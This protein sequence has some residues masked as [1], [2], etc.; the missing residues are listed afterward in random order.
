MSNGATS[1]G[2]RLV[3]PTAATLGLALVAGTVTFMASTADAA[4]LPES[5]L[6]S[7]ATWHYS[8]DNTD[9]AAGSPDR[10]VWT[11]TDYD[12]SAWKT[13]AGPFGAKRG[14][15]TGI[16]SGFPIDTL[17][18]QYIDGTSTDVPTFHFRSTF[19]VPADQLADLGALKGTIT[20]DDAVQVFVNGTQVAGFFDDR[21]EAAPE[22]QRNLTYAGVSNGDP[23]TSTFSVPVDAL[24]PGENTL[25]VALHQDRADSSD[26]Y[27]DVKSLVPVAADAPADVSDVVLHVGA[28]ETHRNLTWYTDQDVPQVVQVA[29]TADLDG[30]EFPANA[31][32]ITASGGPTTSGEFS[33]DATISGLQENTEYS[34]RVGK[35]GSW[36]ETYAFRTQDFSGAFEFLF[37]GDPQIGASGNV[38]RDGAGWADTLDVAQATY[39]D[40][41]MLFSAG[42]QVDHAANEAEYDAV[43]APEQMK[44]VPFVAT[45]GNHDV[46]SK[47]YEQHFNVPNNDPTSGAGTSTSSGGNYWFVY[48]D[49][50][51]VNIN[52][53]NRDH[54]SHEAFLEKVVAEH[55][56]EARW[57]VLAFH[58]SIYSTAAHTNDGDILDRRNAL[59]ATI[60][61]L[62]FDAVLMGHDHSYT[63]SYLLK[64][65][66]VADAGEAAG[67]AEVVA[68]EGE[69]LY[70][71]AN[72]ASGSKYYGVRA[73]DAPFA[74]VINQENVRNYSAVEVTDDTLTITTLRSQAKDGD[75]P[76]NSVV[77]EVTLKRAAT[78]QE[79][80]GDDEQRLQVKVPE[81]GTVPGELVWSI[82]GSNDL[83][84]LGTAESAGDHW[85]AAGEINPVRVTDTRTAGPVWSIS[86]Q[87]SDFASGGSSFDGKYL[88][89]TPRLAE[90]GG[91]AVAGTK[92]T[93]GL[94]GGDGLSVS[95]TLGRADAGHA[96]GSALLGADLDLRIPV[97]VTDG[98]Y[99]AT[100]TLTALS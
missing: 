67:Q 56:D 73:P 6:D 16:G 81:E 9:P 99:Q 45:N 49:V 52:S 69:V 61:D 63:R 1:L 86:A 85:A 8:D 20:F 18:T 3:R 10:L 42:D 26:I 92:V 75:R 98:T 64:D 35:E 74:S 100:L 37:F 58:H 36:S 22:D 96:L 54:A 95:S 24:E 28:D 79:P 83:V 72:S 62:G 33:R 77:D 94:D 50:L 65:G 23:V 70:A 38:A 78:P 13:S 91:G 80:I 88:G 57:K 59:P 15:P 11:G 2:R 40:A 29:R 44:Q 7:G 27:L 4:D 51:F 97:D 14:Q 30:G 46:G 53:N 17:L 89:W 60:S 55:G 47:A 84:D 66:E 76:V 39:P 32:T 21:V 93:S 87:V 34:Y 82:D 48:K 19:D 31:A 12:D 41:E 90:A 71:T 5:Y 43:L 68:E 25:A